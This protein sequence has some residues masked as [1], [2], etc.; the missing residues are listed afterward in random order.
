MLADVSPA[1]QE[2]FVRQLRGL[3][4]HADFV[5]LDVGSGLSRVVRSFWRAADCV[6]LVTTPE[7]VSVMDAYASIKVHSAKVASRA[8]C[9]RW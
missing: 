3:G 2:R 9:I 6:L 8:P 5:I 4:A 1:A 7:L